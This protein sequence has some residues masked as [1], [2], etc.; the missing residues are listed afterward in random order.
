[1][2]LHVH[3]SAAF[4]SIHRPHTGVA[5]FRVRAL[6][7]GC[8]CKLPATRESQVLMMPSKMCELLA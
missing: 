8:I 7:P 2:G 5:A 4:A 3:E 6:V 1:M